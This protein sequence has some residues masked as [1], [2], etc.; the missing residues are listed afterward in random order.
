MNIGLVG[1]P[2][3]GKTALAKDIW[4]NLEESYIVDSYIN[5]VEDRSNIH[6]GSLI[7]YVGNMM[8]ILE[9][10]A[11]ENKARAEYEHVITCGTL[12]ESSI[13]YTA[14]VLAFKETASEADA[15]AYAPRVDASLRM[16]ACF[17]NDI[18]PYDHI[19]Y[20]RLG[21]GTPEAQFIDQQLQVA[22]AGF[23]LRDM[24]ALDVDEDRVKKVMEVINAA[25]GT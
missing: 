14:H 19:F 25:K 21:G 22:T 16:M 17:Y 23:K 7:D 11:L 1:A 13:Y 18:M 20:L 5:D 9:R 10:Y 24:V 6:I 4:Q 15:E 12:F 2:G 3:S 8:V